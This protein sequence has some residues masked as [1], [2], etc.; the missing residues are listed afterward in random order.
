LAEAF[1]IKNELFEIGG[2]VKQIIYFDTQDFFQYQDLVEIEVL[3]A[4]LQVSVVP[5]GNANGCC[6]GSLSMVFF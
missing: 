2:G 4:L 3:F 1:L 5:Q 6:Y